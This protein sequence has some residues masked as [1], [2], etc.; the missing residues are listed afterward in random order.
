[1]LATVA[2]FSIVASI[3][4]PLAAGAEP[5]KLKLAFFTSDRALIYRSTVKP[6]ADAVNLEANGAVEIEAYANGV[7]N[8]DLVAQTQIILS[9]EA[10][11]AWVFPSLTPDQF[12]DNRVFELPGLFSDL[13]EA[14]QVYT[15]VM[16]S[17]TF[18]E[19]NDFVVIGAVC[20]EPFSIHTRLPVASLDDLRGKRIRTSN[21]TQSAVLKEFGAVPELMPV[22]QTNDA[23]NSGAIDGA[24]AVLQTLIDF[25][26]ARLTYHHYFADL[27]VA[28]LM[29]LMNRKK[30]DSLPEAGQNA[31]RK[32]GGE[33]LATRYI[34]GYESYSRFILERLQADPK[35][36]VT[37]PSP[38]D[39]ERLRRVYD[40]V[41][42]DW[43]GGQPHNRQLLTLV[44]AERAKIRA[45]R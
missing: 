38:T 19:Y 7:L 2:R 45:T 42:E 10:D 17:N 39:L 29:L 35:R 31:I 37:F 5:I 30:F 25:G 6:F 27:G 18:K 14:T 36:T 4:L 3:L 16:T 22:N 44:E 43:T 33:W 9:G 28:P 41:I 12:P 24:A 26:I 21:E 34:D 15:R 20:S 8:R 1:M 13:R 11:I 40:G 23:I 32:Y